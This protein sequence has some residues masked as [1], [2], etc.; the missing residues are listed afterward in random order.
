MKPRLDLGEEIARLEGLTI[1]ELRNE[2]RR[3]L[4]MAPPMRLSRDLLIRGIAYRLQE[5]VL[6]GLSK[7][8]VRR[9][10]AAPV[11]AG[12]SVTRR[13]NKPVSLKPGTRLVREWHGVTHVVLVHIDGFEWRGRA[14]SLAVGDR[15]RHHRGALVGTALFRVDGQGSRWR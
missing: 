9:L 13:N 8:V 12:E 11:G 6:G 14:P 3:H 15:T 1:F 7:A 2:W 4:R 10:S 5:K